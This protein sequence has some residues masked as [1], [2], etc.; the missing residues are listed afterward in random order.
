MLYRSENWTFNKTDIRKIKATEMWFFWEN[1]KG[2]VDKEITNEEVLNK[3]IQESKTM[4]DI[5][6]R[7]IS[8]FWANIMRKDILEYLAVTGKV[9]GK[10]V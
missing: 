2:K 3:T 4:S 7:Q 6:I 8:S 9:V 10:R 5:S 1:G